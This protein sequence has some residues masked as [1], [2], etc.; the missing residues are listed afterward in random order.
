MHDASEKYGIPSELYAAILMQESSYDLDAKNCKG[1]V[2][3]DYGIAQINKHTARLYK[4]ELKKLTKDLTYSVESGA[5]VLSWFKEKYGD[6]EP[7]TWYC[8]YNVGTGPKNAIKKNCKKY[9]QL[10]ARWM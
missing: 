7:Q 8:R 6:T 5:K 4:F 1:Q 9:V 2:C 10:V 3:H